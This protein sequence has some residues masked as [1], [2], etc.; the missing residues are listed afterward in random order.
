[1]RILVC[2]HHF[3]PYI[4]GIET[5]SALLAAEFART[6]HDVRVLTQTA[7]DD[8]R[9]WGFPVIRRPSTR[10]LLAHT[11]WCDVFFQNNISLQTLWAALLLRKPWVVAHHTWLTT[12]DGRSGLQTRLKRLLVRFGVNIVIDPSMADHIGK[13]SVLISNPYDSKTFR[14]LPDCRRDRGLVFLGR[15]VSDKGVDILLHALGELRKRNVSPTLTVIGD[16]PEGVALRALAAELEV[17]VQVQFVGPLSGSSLAEALNR[18]KILVVPSKWAEPFGLVAL[19]GIACGCVVIGSEKGGLPNAIG[20]CGWTVPNGNIAALADAIEI[21]IGDESLQARCQ[22]G[23]AQH[24]AR[25]TVSSVAEAYL[26][27][28]QDAVR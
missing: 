27:V 12:A 14:L 7:E 3:S 5:V 9:S 26:Q 21:L 23:A 11:S 22:A 17:D 25:H 8:G 1:M 6:G 15:L 18:H 2:S 4:G 19:E 20:A 28:F 13:A 16:G 24:L 10:Q